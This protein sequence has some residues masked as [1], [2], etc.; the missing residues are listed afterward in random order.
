MNPNPAVVIDA[1]ANPFAK[2]AYYRQVNPLP[3][4]FNAERRL[5][6]A[7]SPPTPRMTVRACF[8]SMVFFYAWEL[9][10]VS[11]CAGPG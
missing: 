11:L 10:G 3:Q 8:G 1:R 4:I 5:G 6:Y 7:V 2:L 9:I